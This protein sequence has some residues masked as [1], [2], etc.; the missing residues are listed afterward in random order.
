[1]RILVAMLTF[2]WFAPAWA[3]EEQIVFTQSANGTRNTRP[4]TIKPHW[5]IRWVSKEGIV[6]SVVPADPDQKNPLAKLPIA[7][8][9]QL[10][11]GDGSTYIER[12]G[13]FYLSITSMG[14]WTI[15]VVQLP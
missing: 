6:V 4:F 13:K 2:L 8:G 12:G 11:P 9:T 14:D 10:T 5:E 15:T 3:A 7:S 1:M